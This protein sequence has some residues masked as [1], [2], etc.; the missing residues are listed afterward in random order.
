M[1]TEYEC[2]GRF[3]VAL[4]LFTELLKLGFVPT[5]SALVSTP[6]AISNAMINEYSSLPKKKSGHW[7]A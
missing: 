1:I 2:N 6:S 5:H 7:T 3:S 4:Q